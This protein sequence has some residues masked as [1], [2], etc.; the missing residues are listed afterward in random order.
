MKGAADWFHELSPP[1]AVVRAVHELIETRGVT[2]YDLFATVCGIAQEQQ[3][4][5]GARYARPASLR[6]LSVLIGPI[7]DRD[8]F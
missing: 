2:P 4:E 8:R 5:Q 6:I 1:A 3:A 7:F